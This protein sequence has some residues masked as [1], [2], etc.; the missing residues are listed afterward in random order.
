MFL[1]NGL[2]FKLEIF[3]WVIDYYYLIFEYVFL[4]WIFLVR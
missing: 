4:I 2:D 1:K 3:D